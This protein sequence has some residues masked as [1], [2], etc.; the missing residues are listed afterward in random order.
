MRLKFIFIIT[1]LVCLSTVCFPQAK[2][3]AIQAKNFVGKRVIVTGIV[4]QISESTTGGIILNIGERFR[5]NEL[6]AVINKPDLGNFVN[7]IE[8]RGRTVEITGTIT[9]SK[10]SPQIILKN[11]VQ[12]KILY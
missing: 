2:I 9:G 3:K 11:T 12:I 6:V 8:C 4:A 5:Y 10:G 7:I 1:F